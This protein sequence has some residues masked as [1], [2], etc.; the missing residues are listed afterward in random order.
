MKLTLPLIAASA[1][2]ALAVPAIASANAQ[3]TDDAV[4]EAQVEAAAEAPVES[5]VAGTEMPAVAA[6]AAD[7]S[8]EQEPEE[9][10]LICRSIRLDASSRRK[11]RV[12]RTQ[13]GWRQLNQR[14]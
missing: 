10:A 13:E 14:R 7:A 4:T 1:V 5:A 12:C 3:Q 2:F 9:E 6:P 8:A 11:T